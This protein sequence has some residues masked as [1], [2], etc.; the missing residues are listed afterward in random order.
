MKLK[1]LLK[2]PGI[3]TRSPCPAYKTLDNNKKNIL[4]QLVNASNNDELK[5]LYDIALLQCSVVNEIVIDSD[6]DYFDS[7]YD[8]PPHIER[9][10]NEAIAS[11]AYL[12]SQPDTLESDQIS[13]SEISQTVHYPLVETM[14]RRQMHIESL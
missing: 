10:D 11:R 12:P 4:K 9:V 5:E 14:I 1:G 13:G 7:I 3:F 8:G 6:E 2:K